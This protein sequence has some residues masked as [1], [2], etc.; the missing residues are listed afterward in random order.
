MQGTRLPKISNLQNKLGR[1]VDR[2]NK[3]DIL[4]RIKRIEGQIQGIHRM[5][6]S[7]RYCPDILTQI[8]AAKSA[9]ESMAMVLIEDHATHC[10]VSDIQK[11]KS[12]SAISE[13]MKILKGFNRI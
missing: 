7:D 5:I 10:I 9:L 1:H 12:N 3:S 2:K 6:E 4:K 8:N 11:G 13:L